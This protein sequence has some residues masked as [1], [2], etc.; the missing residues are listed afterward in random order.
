MTQQN[1]SYSKKIVLI[2]STNYE[3]LVSIAKEHYQYG[4]SVYQD[5]NGGLLSTE[6]ITYHHFIL[7]YWHK[8]DGVWSEYQHTVFDECI[9]KV[10]EFTKGWNC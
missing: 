3:E 6:P 2:T 1:Y 9:A 8:I 5:A 7:S 4:F 10:N